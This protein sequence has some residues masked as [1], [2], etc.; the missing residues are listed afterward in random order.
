MLKYCIEPN[1]TARATAINEKLAVRKVRHYDVRNCP[2]TA[3]FFLSR[4]FLCF[5]KFALS[6]N[7]H[8]NG[9]RNRIVVLL[10]MT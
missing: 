10:E 7:P 8:R 1:C 6:V 2:S 9:V 4:T 5:A 3:W